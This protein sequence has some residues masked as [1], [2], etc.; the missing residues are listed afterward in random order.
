MRI[1]ATTVLALLALPAFAQGYHAH[2]GFYLSGSLSPAWGDVHQSVSNGPY[3]DTTFGG[4]A[5]L[6]L[7]LRVGGAISRNNIISFDISSRAMVNP[8]VTSGGLSTNDGN[9]SSIGAAIF[10]V[11]FTHYFMPAN[12]FLSVTL[13]QGAFTAKFDGNTGTSQQ[14]FGYIVRAGKEWWVA[15]RVGLG[16]VGGVSHLSA[17]D[18]SDPNYPGY[19][20]T[21][22]TTGY[23]VGFSATFN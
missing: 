14:G 6:Q 12:A 15:R 20:S 21:F 18:K 8:T 17:N 1:L 9:N 16:I 3:G 5:G 10:G 7:D 11:G 2:E 22:T 19:A 13:G 4:T 23:F